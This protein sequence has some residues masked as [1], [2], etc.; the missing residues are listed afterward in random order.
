MQHSLTHG[1]GLTLI[2]RQAQ[3]EHGVRRALLQAVEDVYRPVR[4]AVI[5][6][7][8][9]RLRLFVQE[10]QDLRSAQP[11]LL[12]EAGDDYAD[13]RHTAKF[14]SPG[15]L[16][17]RRPNRELTRESRIR[18]FF[19]TAVMCRAA[20]PRHQPGCLGARGDAHQAFLHHLDDPHGD[21]AREE[22]SQ[23]ERSEPRA[24]QQMAHLV[25]GIPPVMTE[26]FVV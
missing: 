21:E 25:V 12:V 6:E 23:L 14:D 11:V 18:T 1:F 4:T 15:T 16:R 2:H 8:D 24:F 7:A 22:V 13:F 19:S 10:L 17:P 3:D 20:L 5:H 26:R 9:R